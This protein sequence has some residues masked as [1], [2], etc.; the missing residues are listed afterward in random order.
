[1]IEK[2]KEGL[3]WC[4]AVVFWATAIAI[5]LSILYLFWFKAI[6]DIVGL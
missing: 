4:V 6:P 3:G 2:L 5:A 1:M